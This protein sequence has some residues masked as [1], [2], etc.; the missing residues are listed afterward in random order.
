VNCS[1]PSAFVRGSTVV[2]PRREEHSACS[3]FLRGPLPR[4]SA[5]QVRVL[6]RPSFAFLRGPT[7]LLP[8][9]MRVVMLDVAFRSLY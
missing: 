3:A 7:D 5:A 4:P 1:G 6:P 2:R 8:R 9:L